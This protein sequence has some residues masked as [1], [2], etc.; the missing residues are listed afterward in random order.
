MEVKNRM[1][2]WQLGAKNLET[3]FCTLLLLLGL[4]T[5]GTYWYLF[6]QKQAICFSFLFYVTTLKSAASRIFLKL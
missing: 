1:S 5:F 3:I 4:I 2:E 6:V